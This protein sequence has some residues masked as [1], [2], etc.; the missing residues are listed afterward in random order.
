MTVSA[1]HRDIADESRE[2]ILELRDVISGTLT[3][4][5][6]PNYSPGVTFRHCYGLGLA[7]QHLTLTIRWRS[8]VHTQGVCTAGFCLAR[9]ANAR[10]RRYDLYIHLG[11]IWGPP[12]PPLSRG[13]ILARTGSASGPVCVFMTI[14]STPTHG[15]D[16]YRI[17]VYSNTTLM[18]GDLAILCLTHGTP[19]S[20]AEGTSQG[21]S[22][23]PTSTRTERIQQYEVARLLTAQPGA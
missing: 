10:L 17:A 20:E 7:L 19:L 2:C 16:G 5:I 12:D 9:T 11:F 3:L 6:Y 14:S 15:P 23:C 13:R 21:R 8:T 22:L 1:A 4:H 18:L